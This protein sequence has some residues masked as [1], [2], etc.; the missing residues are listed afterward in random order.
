MDCEEAGTLGDFRYIRGE[1]M[2]IKIPA[3]FLQRTEGPGRGTR[4][5]AERVFHLPNQ[6]RGWSSPQL[7]TLFDWGGRCSGDRVP[8]DCEETRFS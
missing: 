6:I 8:A 7:S 2:K 1:E 5:L 4:W 3:L